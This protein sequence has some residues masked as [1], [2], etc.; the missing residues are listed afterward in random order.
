MHTH[1]HTQVLTLYFSLSHTHAP[2]TTHHI[3]TSIDAEMRKRVHKL[4]NAS[5]EGRLS[6]QRPFFKEKKP[7][8]MSPKPTVERPMMVKYRDAIYLS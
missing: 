4:C 1:T 3:H 6:R 2:Y 5:T 7:G 8:V